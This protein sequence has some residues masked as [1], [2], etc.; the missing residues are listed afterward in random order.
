MMLELWMKISLH[1]LRITLISLRHKHTTQRHLIL[2]QQAGVYI[3]HEMERVS[4]VIGYY[5]QSRDLLLPLTTSGKLMSSLEYKGRWKRRRIVGYDVFWS[6]RA[7]VM[8]HVWGNKRNFGIDGISGTLF[9]GFYVEN[10]YLGR[11]QY[12]TVKFQGYWAKTFQ[13]WATI[14]P[15]WEHWAISKICCSIKFGKVDSR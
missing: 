8:H 5:Q 7:Q 10:Y 15:S 1:L 14:T 4:N 13:M 9:S 6:F 3:F 12:D 11:D 2:H